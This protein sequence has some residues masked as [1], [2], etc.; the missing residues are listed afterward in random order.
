MIF[1]TKTIIGDFMNKLNNY[2]SL[3]NQIHDIEN[4]L[5]LDSDIILN[6]DED[7]DYLIIDKENVTIDGNN[8]CIDAKGKEGIFKIN[9]D[10]VTLKNI[11]FKNAKYGQLLMNTDH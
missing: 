1:L 8:H 6:D 4:E 5:I 2:A 3:N 9:A 7:V 11:V 10:G